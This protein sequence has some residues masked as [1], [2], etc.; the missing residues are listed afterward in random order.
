MG[1]SSI[2]TSLVYSH[3]LVHTYK[4]KREQP[5]HTFLAETFVQRTHFCIFMNA[6]DVFNDPHKFLFSAI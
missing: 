1:Q 3:L 5:I 2:S 6:L 4:H